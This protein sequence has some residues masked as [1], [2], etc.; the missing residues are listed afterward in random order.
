[1]LISCVPYL[2]IGFQVVIQHVHADCEIARVE[3]V[4][5]IPSLGTKLAT[6]TD[7]SVEVAEGKQDDL[8]LSLTCTHLQRILQNVGKP[9]SADHIHV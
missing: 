2:C 4:R 3:R 9:C 8:E 6:F 1:M 7:D 5:T